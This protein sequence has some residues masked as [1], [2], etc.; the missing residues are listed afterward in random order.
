[1]ADPFAPSRLVRQLP[2]SKQTCFTKSYARAVELSA[3]ALAE[4]RRSRHPTQPYDE[5]NVRACCKAID[6]FI[7]KTV[8]TRP[9]SDLCSLG[10]QPRHAQ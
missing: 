2:G 4:L 3:E 9:R 8:R 5:H 10:H 6:G 7:L 1:M